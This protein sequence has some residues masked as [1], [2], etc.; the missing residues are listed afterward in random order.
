MNKMRFR[1]IKEGLP[2]A[3]QILDMHVRSWGKEF[4]HTLAVVAVVAVDKAVVAV[5]KVVVHTSVQHR[6]VVQSWA[7]GRMA[8]HI[9]AKDTCFVVM[10]VEE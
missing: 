7:G 6:L 4:V 3:G 2:L 9:M 10:I 1:C 5:D 8:V